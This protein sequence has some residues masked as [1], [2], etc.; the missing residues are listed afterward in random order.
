MWSDVRMWAELQ[1]ER[2][3][4]GVKFRKSLSE[5]GICKLGLEWGKAPATGTSCGR[6]FCVGHTVFAETFKEEK[7]AM[8]GSF[9]PAFKHIQVA[10]KYFFHAYSNYYP[11]FLQSVT[12]FL[13]NFSVLFYIFY[14]HFSNAMCLSYPEFH[15][16]WFCQDFLNIDITQYSLLCPHY[17][18]TYTVFLSDSIYTH[19]DISKRK[20]P[21]L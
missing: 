17:L 11:D 8:S 12:N 21:I 19:D 3:E 13:N 5:E 2:T 9:A 1:R 15:K 6:T 18:P 10:K 14:S 16:N 7:K 4:Y 20:T